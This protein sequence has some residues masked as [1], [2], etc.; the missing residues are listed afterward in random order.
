MQQ[1]INEGGV[2]ENQV[3]LMEVLNPGY[4]NQLNEHSLLLE[5][6]ESID[7]ELVIQKEMHEVIKRESDMIEIFI[8]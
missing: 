7:D 5:L 4:T 2:L 6:N 8:P 3:M 1:M